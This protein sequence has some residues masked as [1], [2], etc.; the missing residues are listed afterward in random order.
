MPE[1]PEV[2]TIRQIISKDIVNKV[3]DKVEIL[4]K[5]QFIGNPKILKDKK[6]VDVQRKG[7]VM[8]I[9]LDNNL[10]I[11]IHLK[12][13]GQLLFSKNFPQSEFKTQI[14]FTQTNKMPSKTPG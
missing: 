12:L 9:K 13:T 14:P 8:A 3:I 2:E 11:S 6:I 10:F 1:L 7:K 5:K 4:E